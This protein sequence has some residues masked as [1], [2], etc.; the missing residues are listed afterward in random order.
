M[1]GLREARFCMT[2]MSF[3]LKAS[4][5]KAPIN[6]IEV[7]TTVVDLL[8]VNPSRFPFL[9]YGDVLLPPVPNTCQRLSQM[10][11]RV[12]IMTDSGQKHLPVKFIDSAHGTVQAMWRVN[13]MRSG[14][15]NRLL[16]DCS[17]GTRV[18]AA[19]H[20]RQSPE[21]IRHNS[22][23]AA[24]RCLRVEGVGVIFGHAGH[25]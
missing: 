11:G 2:Y 14:S 4:I 16:A 21:H 6:Q 13:G 19:E 23:A 8:V 18:V 24:R 1:L 20:A 22:H 3:A 25:H 10:N 15:S 9:D 17:K 7:L 5:L 12:D